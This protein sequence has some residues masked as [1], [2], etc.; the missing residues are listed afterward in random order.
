MLFLGKIKD[1]EKV[2]AD[3]RKRLSLADFLAVPNK[4]HLLWI[5]W[6]N[7]KMFIEASPFGSEEYYIETLIYVSYI[8]QKI[9]DYSQTNMLSEDETVKCILSEM[10]NYV[11][12]L[13][14]GY[15]K[16]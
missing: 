13:D 15:F 6:S 1:A 16:R 2:L 8:A 9:E 11:N 10:Q 14:L 7:A 5:Q 12:W 4:K 3:L